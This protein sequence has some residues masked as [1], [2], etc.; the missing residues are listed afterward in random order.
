MMDAETRA[1]CEWE[2]GEEEEGGG[3]YDKGREED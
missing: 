3:D 1:C 2:T